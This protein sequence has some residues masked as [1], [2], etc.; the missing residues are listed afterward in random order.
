MSLLPA[1]LRSRLRKDPPA[2]P[3]EPGDDSRDDI[4]KLMPPAQSEKAEQAEQRDKRPEEGHNVHPVAAM[5]LTRLSIDNDGR[6]YWDGKPVEVHRRL[7]MSRRQV[8]G[9]SLLA[10][11]IVGGAAGAVMQGTAAAYDW[12]CKFGWATTYCP[13]PPPVTPPPRPDIPA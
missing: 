7:M 8:I 13:A 10:L 12:A 2:P 3:A 11:V 5:D 6:L 1:A 4:F 9:A